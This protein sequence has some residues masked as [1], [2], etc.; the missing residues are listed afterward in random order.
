M[1]HEI[2]AAGANII[3]LPR[4]SDGFLFSK[5]TVCVEIHELRNGF[6]GNDLDQIFAD[7]LEWV[8]EC[9]ILL[10]HAMD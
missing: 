3:I 4:G 1:M 8:K 2:L 7:A 10:W 5:Y 9:Q 6:I